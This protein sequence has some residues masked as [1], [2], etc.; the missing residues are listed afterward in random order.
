MSSASR[1][2]ILSAALAALTSAYARAGTEQSTATSASSSATEALQEVTVTAQ[3]AKLAKR[4]S[5]FVENVAAPEDENGLPRW[6]EPVCPLVLGLNQETDAFIRERILDVAQTARLPVAYKTCRSNL[7]VVVTENPKAFLSGLGKLG[8]IDVFGDVFNPCKHISNFDIDEFAVTPRAVSV[9]YQTNTT[10]RWGK[11]AAASSDFCY[12][13]S[14]A[15]RVARAALYDFSSVWVIA[16]YSRLR[17][18]TAGQFA[19]YIAMVSLAKIAPGAHIGEAPSIL[20][21]FQGT[22]KAAP[23][24]LT[25]W[26]QAFLKS[27]YSPVA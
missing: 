18:V 26:D 1:A 13:S 3:R 23:A 15:S 10:D 20:Q 5:K 9:W 16:D 19:D 7:F 6:N 25:E 8:R 12:V 14:D 24:G 4:I 17:G 22:P 11:A 27:L 2:L 21:L